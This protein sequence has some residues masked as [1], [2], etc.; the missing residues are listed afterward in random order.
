MADDVLDFA[1]DANAKEPALGGMLLRD[2]SLIVA[3]LALFGGAH[4]WAQDAN[5]ALAQVT[6][7]AAS[8]IVGWLITGM[9]HEWGHYAGAKLAGAIAPRVQLPGFSFFR[10]NFDLEKNSVGQFA[11]MSIGGNLAHWGAVVAAILLMPMT[12]TP[13]VTF[14]A[15]AV[16]FAVFASVIEWPI[17][18][19]AISGRVR[20]AEAFSHLSRNFLRWH[21]VVGGAGGLA[22]LY[23]VQ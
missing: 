19:R 12:T 10:Y 20:P 2:A 15:A 7:I 4:A 9:F 1:Q 8:L 21:Y 6:A 11:A 14:I 13:Q 18:A 16:A 5:F 3:A 23:Y 17:I 22:F